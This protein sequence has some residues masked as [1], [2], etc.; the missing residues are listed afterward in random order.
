MSDSFDPSVFLSTTFTAP[1]I[2]ERLLCPVGEWMGTVD[3]LEARPWKG[4]E[5]PTKSGVTLDV[6]WSIEDAEVKE[7]CKRDKVVVRQSI[8]FSYLEDGMTLDMEKAKNDVNFGKLRA[9]VGLNDDEFS[10]QMLPGRSAKVRVSHRPYTDKAGQQ[11][12]QEEVA[13]V[14]AL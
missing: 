14:A 10:P 5:D 11:A 8:M 13:G 12:L 6:F 9:A 4:K 7:A 1:S 2:T 3:K